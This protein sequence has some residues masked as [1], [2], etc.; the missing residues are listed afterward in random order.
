MSD[1]FKRIFGYCPICKRYFKICKHRNIK[2][3]NFQDI[4]IKAYCCKKCLN[5]AEKLWNS[6]CKK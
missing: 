2:V 1:N 6:V 5:K 3:Y 4:D